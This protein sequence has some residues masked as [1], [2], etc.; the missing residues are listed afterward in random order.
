MERLKI[1]KA[2][3]DVQRTRAA[4]RSDLQKNFDQL[5]VSSTACRQGSGKA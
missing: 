2:Q 1:Q 3:T 4:L 5:L